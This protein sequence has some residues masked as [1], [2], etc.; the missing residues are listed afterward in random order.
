M[1]S[2]SR[3]TLTFTTDGGLPSTWMS[4][5]SSASIGPAFMNTSGACSAPSKFKRPAESASSTGSV[6]GY[7]SRIGASAA[8][9]REAG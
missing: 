9:V 8:S 7:S 5:S 1:R 6:T 4:N 3:A 2:R